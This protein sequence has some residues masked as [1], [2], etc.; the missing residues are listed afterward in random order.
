MSS[1][2]KRFWGSGT[3]CTRSENTEAAEKM[4]AKLAEMIALRNQQDEKFGPVIANPVATTRKISNAIINVR[5]GP[6]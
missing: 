6:M 5:P 1:C 3:P 2:A 4:N